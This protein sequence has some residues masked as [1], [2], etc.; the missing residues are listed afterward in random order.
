MMNADYKSVI[1]LS[2]DR[3]RK[4]GVKEDQVFSS[5]IIGQTELQEKFAENRDMIL[6]ASPYMEQLINFVKGHN[7]FA[8][9]PMERDAY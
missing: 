4:L 8:L 5:K 1:E 6:T 3:C 7:F 2:H 9:L